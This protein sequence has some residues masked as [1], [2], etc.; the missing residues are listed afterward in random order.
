MD[1]IF[2]L[3]VGVVCAFA[4]YK[5]AEGKNRNTALA[6]CMGFLFGIIALIVYTVLGKKE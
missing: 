1:I 6:A 3:I 5:L 2:S 4:C